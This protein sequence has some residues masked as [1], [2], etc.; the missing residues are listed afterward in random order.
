MASTLMVVDCAHGMAQGCCLAGMAGPI[1]CTFW[2][3]PQARASCFFCNAPDPRPPQKTKVTIVGNNEIY[4]WEHLMK[5]FLVHK[6]P[7]PSPPP[8]PPP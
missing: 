8:P 5:P 6:L 2:G 1:K 7:G 4:R 3:N